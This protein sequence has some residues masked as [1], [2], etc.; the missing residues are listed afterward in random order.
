MPVRLKDIDTTLRKLLKPE[1]F[2]DYCP[3]GIQ[4]EGKGEIQ[5]IVTGVTASRALIE[6]AI[7]KEADL[8]LVHH[9]YFWKGEEVTITGLKKVRIQLLLSKDISLCAY[10]LPLDAH[11]RLGNNAQLAKILGIIQQ[12]PLGTAKKHPLVLS[13]NLSEPQSFNQFEASDL[14]LF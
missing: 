11:P 13:G 8:I 9:G 1:E 10:H 14:M 5:K 3:N 7:L 4:V 6:A 2:E 12:A